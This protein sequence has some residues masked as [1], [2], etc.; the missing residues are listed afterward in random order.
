MITA[1]QKNDRMITGYRD[2]AHRSCLARQRRT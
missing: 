2:H 1:I